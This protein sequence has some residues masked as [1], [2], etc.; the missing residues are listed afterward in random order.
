MEWYVEVCI[1]TAPFGEDVSERI[2]YKNESAAEK[3]ER[4]VNIN[5]NHKQYFTRI[6]SEE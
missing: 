4:G 5:L 6:V 2:K 1:K 3:V